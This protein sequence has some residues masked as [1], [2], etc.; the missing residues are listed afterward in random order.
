M[1]RTL[2]SIALLAFPALALPGC[3][4]A[5]SCVAGA[6]ASC[7]CTTGA[8]GAQV[9]QSDGTFG[10][11]VC[12][13][14][15]GGGASDGGGGPDD[16]GG[17]R[18]A[19]DDDAGGSTDAAT[20]TDAGGPVD[21]IVSIAGAASWSCAAHSDGRALCWGGE[22]GPGFACVDTQPV[23][24]AVAGVTDTREI[25]VARYHVCARRG[26]GQVVCWGEG[27][28]GELG[29]GRSMTST[30]PVTA[31]GIADARQ[32]GV[33][34]NHSCALR[35][36]ASVWC[37]GRNDH[38]QVGSG[39]VGDP[40]PMPSRVM[41]ISDAVQLAASGESSCARRAGGTIRC[42]GENLYGRLGNGATDRGT[43][44]PSDVVGIDDAVDVSVGEAHACAVRADG[45][46]WCWGYGDGGRLGN[47][48]T[49]D[50]SVPVEVSGIDDAVLVGALGS[51]S[52]A[53]R[54]TGALW[55]WGQGVRGQLGDGELMNRAVP[56]EADPIGGSVVEISGGLY[57][58]CAATADG[59]LY[60]WGGGCGAS[61][62]AVDE[63]VPR[64]VAIP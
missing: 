7:T 53:L 38:G 48:G 52:C 33:G 13:G 14:T 46:V 40:V 60:C 26:A 55:C 5:A 50:S 18:D 32:I 2:A 51:H 22:I 31:M 27:R 45:T 23:P 30:S 47:G 44:I 64:R 28:E 63:P 8:P 20:G 57:H 3:D 19:G 24:T 37:W 17:P 29:D 49:S 16:A 21:G 41:G 25:A 43:G 1:H 36:D 59:A 54:A 6:S 58:T 34:D 15:D 39:G 62:S 61:G 4:G 35:S 9:C 11:C 42:W 12:A 10:E 56:V